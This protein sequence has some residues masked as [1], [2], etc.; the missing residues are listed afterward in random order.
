M[1]NVDGAHI[2]IA[3]LLPKK[4]SKPQRR[5]NGTFPP[6]GS[7]CPRPRR[8]E[9][10]MPRQFAG[11]LLVSGIMLVSVA[12]AEPIGN[13]DEIGAAILPCW[14]A[15]AESKG[16]Y[17]TLAFSFKSDGTLIGTPRPTEINVAGDAEAR[18]RYVDAAIAAINGCLP[19]EFSADFAE[20]V[21]G[22]DFTL[23]F[24]SSGIQS[25]SPE[26]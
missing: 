21:A 26:N 23:R 19:L 8:S 15:P 18:Q 20:G 17:V 13:A 4:W 2:A 7:T 10:M 16:S 14:K 24:G 6:S 3:F 22:Q 25:V 12:S 5:A 1:E 9:N 11:L